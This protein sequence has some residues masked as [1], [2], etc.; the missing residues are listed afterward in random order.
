[1]PKGKM[2]Y[3]GGHKK[4]RGSKGKTGGAKVAG[5]YAK[6]NKPKYSGAMS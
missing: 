1:M 6:N 2:S 5:G 4:K 3:G